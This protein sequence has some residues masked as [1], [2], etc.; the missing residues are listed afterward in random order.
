ML[1]TIFAASAVITLSTSV[2]ADGWT[3]TGSNGGSGS[4]SSSCERSGSGSLICSG[5]GT[6]IG[7]NGAVR[8]R[9][10]SREITRGSVI[11]SKTVIRN[12]R[13]RSFS[14]SL[15]RRSQ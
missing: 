9:S 4:G 13:E 8:E 1:K 15:N 5:V 3:A 11:G 10:S 12:G 6:W 14:W 2:H 7:A